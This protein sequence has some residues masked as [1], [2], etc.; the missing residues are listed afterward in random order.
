MASGISEGVFPADRRAATEHDEVLW[1]GAREAPDAFAT[2]LC[3]GEVLWVD[4]LWVR[5]A[6]RRHGLATQLFEK[7]EHIAALRGLNGVSLGSLIGNTT[8]TKFSLKR[9]FE[10]GAIVWTRKV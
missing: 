2:F 9:G 6:K 4:L 5:P 3:E 1:I 10:P 7:I 8:M